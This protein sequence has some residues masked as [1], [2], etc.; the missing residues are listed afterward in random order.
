MV[1]VDVLAQ[2]KQAQS[3]NGIKHSDYLRYRRFCCRKMQ[4]L[5]SAAHFTFGR[6]R[7]FEKRQYT[8][9]ECSDPK[10]ATMLLFNAER[11]WSSAMQLRQ[12]LML[13]P[14]SHTR[15]HLLRRLR[16]AVKWSEHLYAVTSADTK[17][18]LEASAYHHIM[19]AY[20]DLEVKHAE[21]AHMHLQQAK[22][23]LER[24]RDV[25]DS[26]EA[27][28]Y[29]DKLQS[30]APMLSLCRS[31]LHH[32]V[33]DSELLELKFSSNTDELV[34]AQIEALLAE[35]RQ[36]RV[37]A[38]GEVEIRGKRFTIKN[39]K[40]REALRRAEE[41]ASAMEKAADRLEVYTVMFS[42][43]DEAARL[44]KKD[45]D[46]KQAQGEVGE[47]ELWG[48]VLQSVIELKKAKVVE[49]N[50]ELARQAELRFEDDSD[51]VFRG[52][53]ARPGRLND[54]I[55]IYDTVLTS[56]RA[57]GDSAQELELRGK[58]AYY[59]SLSLLYSERYLESYALLQ[60][61]EEL[62]Y[63]PPPVLKLMVKL[64]AFLQANMNVPDIAGLSLTGKDEDFPP[65]YEPMPP[66]PV[67]FDLA[68]DFIQYP[69]LNS[70]F[71]AQSK[72]LLSRL[73]WR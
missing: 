50:L 5:R 14:S 69:D 56:V 23:V 28:K 60:R 29:T 32:S 13:K 21:S 35:S 18:N 71:K 30:I 52:G 8:T 49:R 4:R 33:P 66:K 20:L 6:G 53:K 41:A 15:N 51:T 67:F 3:L 48:Q 46:E 10:V 43:Y 42:H 37:E 57:L 55:K 39:E 40:A 19:C 9:E 70:R 25:S 62:H 34:T 2:V 64:K 36:Q 61:C 72:G 65:K 16:K 54:I 38:A 63:T 1:K 31:L 7:T 68:W 73:F 27:V 44:I 26:L 24:L 45:K 11:A 17:T 12:H 59:V 58:R 47:A 22:N